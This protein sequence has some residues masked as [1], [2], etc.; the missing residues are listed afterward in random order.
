[1]VRSTIYQEKT[2]KRER[3]TEKRNRKQ[4]I[5]TKG[6]E[7]KAHDRVGRGEKQVNARQKDHP[8]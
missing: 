3:K 6:T 7:G 2:R 8:K 1:M 4:K 5:G